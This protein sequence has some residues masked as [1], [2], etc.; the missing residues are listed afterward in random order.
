MLKILR[1]LNSFPLLKSYEV[2]DFKQGKDFYYIRIKAELKNET[3]LYI[4]L[5]VSDEEY[6]YS[7]HWQRGDGELIVRW[8]NSPHHREIET[9]PHH[10]HIKD[11]IEAS[12]EIGLKEVL[13]YIF[14]MSKK[15]D[16]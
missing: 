13:K 4:R 6:N 15:E 2:I 10:R 16:D 5:Y 12:K 1:L 3:S 11:R 7:Y 8:D 9:F 14:N